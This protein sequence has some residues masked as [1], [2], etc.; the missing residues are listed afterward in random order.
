MRKIINDRAYDTDTAE[1]LFRFVGDL[2]QNDY[3]F[4][5][6]TLYRKKNGE[7]FMLCEGDAMSPYLRGNGVEPVMGG[8]I[9]VLEES[10]IREWAQFHM[11]G[12]EYEAIFGKVEE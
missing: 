1:L 8:E 12:D 9:Q 11:T 6:Q 3:R 5:A 4:F 7:F 2:E 10:E